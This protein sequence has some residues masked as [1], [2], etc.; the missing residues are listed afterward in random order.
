MSTNYEKESLKVNAG[1]ACSLS[2]SV[3][4]SLHNTF[5]ICLSG[6]SNENAMNEYISLVEELK[7]KYGI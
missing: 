6:K 1:L 4:F 2:L 3:F 5:L 7:Q